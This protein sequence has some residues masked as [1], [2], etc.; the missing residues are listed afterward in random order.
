MRHKATHSGEEA[1]VD[2]TPMLDIVFIMLIF[3]IVTATF[4]NEAGLDVTKPDNQDTPQSAVKSMRIL[5]TETD[6]IL[7]DM[8][9]VDSR[10][11]RANVERFLGENPKGS[12]LIQTHRRAST[13]VVV[14]V[15]DQVTAAGAPVSVAA[16]ADK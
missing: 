2:L 10:A 14:K 15:M 12:V 9:D 13:G 8:R 3:F 7:I 1:K 5:V 6:R 4:V 16:S 11:V